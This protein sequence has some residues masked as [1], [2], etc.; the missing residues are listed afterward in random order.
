MALV[1]PR[2]PQ[3]KLADPFRLTEH[4]RALIASRRSDFVVLNAT[5]IGDESGSGDSSSGDGGDGTR[6]RMTLDLRRA[7]VTTHVTGE[8]P[9]DDYEHHVI[10][11][12]NMTA[13]EDA[14]QAREDLLAEER[15]P[16]RRF[17]DDLMAAA[18]LQAL[19]DVTVRV[20]PQYYQRHFAPD[21][22][23]HFRL[24]FPAP[25]APE[26]LARIRQL[27]LPDDAV[28]SVYG[29]AA[30]PSVVASP[31]LVRL[32]TGE[33]DVAAMAPEGDSNGTA[34]AKLPED[35]VDAIFDSVS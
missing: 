23:A 15:R 10:G 20:T 1:K 18:I 30:P 13:S 5:A 6:L 35:V 29:I 21:L 31:D 34:V 3:L 28:A 22:I 25:P 16:I 7:N 12:A 14:L 33:V 27:A 24:E 11:A 32:F 9:R 8:R 26:V 19:D 17:V 2:D 4:A